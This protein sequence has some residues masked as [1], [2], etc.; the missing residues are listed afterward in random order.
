MAACTRDHDIDAKIALLPDSQAGSGRHK[1]VG[2]AYERGFAAGR[3]KEEELHLDLA[4]LDDSQAGA[5]RHKSAHAAF[6]LG[7]FDGVKAI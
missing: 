3:R 7:Y 1:C 6:A 5:G 2:C 4:S